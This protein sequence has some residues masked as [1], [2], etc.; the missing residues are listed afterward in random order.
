[1]KTALLFPGQGSQ[2]VGMGRD[3]AREFP[4]AQRT[5]EEADDALGFAISEICWNGPEDR[6]TLTENTQPAILTNSIAVLRALESELDVGFDVTAGHSL[7][8]L[9]ALV[10]AGALDLGDAVKLVHLRGKAMQHAV[11]A[12]QGGMA[13]IMGLELDAV[14]AVC[15]QARHD[16]DDQVCSPANLNGAGQIVISGHAEAVARAVALAQQKGARR[17]LSLQV[18]APFHCALM[19]PAAEA[20]QEALE[21]VA[22]H[23]LKVPVVANVDAE[24]N[25]DAG[26]IK[27]L[28]VDQVT[29]PVRWEACVK[30]LARLGVERAYELG[31]GSV[32]RGLVRRIAKDIQVTTIG[33]PHEVRA[34][35]AA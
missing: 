3:L 1:M 34:F 4:A 26:R 16:G 19:A 23:P 7:G 10:A 24:P 13:A 5:F 31:S 21:R 18:S 14:Q 32:L 25:Q 22:I 12:G 30:T 8:E 2:R 6:L 20:L 15:D 35:P 29:Q 33:E 27:R 17:A 11:P 28:L 9:S